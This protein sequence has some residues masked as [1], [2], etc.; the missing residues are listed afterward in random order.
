MREENVQFL[1]KRL[2][3]SA[4]VSPYS[5]M[6]PPLL[7]SL[8][9]SFTSTTFSPLQP[10]ASFTPHDGRKLSQI[11]PQCCTFENSFIHLALTLLLSD[12]V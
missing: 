7:G 12:L 10:S 11:S 4:P 8:I 5:L 6:G 9:H 3:F 1:P 2:E